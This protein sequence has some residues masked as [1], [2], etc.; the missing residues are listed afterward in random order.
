MRTISKFSCSDFLSRTLFL[1]KLQLTDPFAIS[2]CALLPDA[3][4]H[5]RA[6]AEH[7]VQPAALFGEFLAAKAAQIALGAF[8][9]PTL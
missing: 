2:C 3:C 7:L 5:G 9:F 4:A 6:S 8:E 1:S